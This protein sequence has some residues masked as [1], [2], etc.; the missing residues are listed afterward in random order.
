MKTRDEK[1]KKRTKE[2]ITLSYTEKY[3]FVE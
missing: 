1:R 2:K 3:K